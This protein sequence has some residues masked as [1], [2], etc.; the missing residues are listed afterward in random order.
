M[1]I[2][3]FLCCLIL[4]VRFAEPANA[5]VTVIQLDDRFRI[6]KDGA[7]VT[8]WHFKSWAV[9]YLYPVIGPNGENITRHYP[10][11]DGVPGESKDHPHH[12]SIRFSHRDLN[13]YSF[14]SPDSPKD[15]RARVD[16]VKVEKAEGGESSAELI[17]IN[18]WFG[19]ETL[20]LKERLRL[21]FTLLENNE[22]LIDYD[23]TLTAA[24]VDAT[25]VDQKDGGLGVRVA[26]TMRVAGKDKTPGKGTIQNSKGDKNEAAWGKRAEWADYYGPDASGKTVG[27]ATFDHPSNLRYP[28]HW[29]ART[30][31][32]ITANRFGTGHFEAKSGAKKGDGNYTIKKGE[33][34]TLRHRLYLHH[35]STEEA[36]VAERYQAY[37]QEK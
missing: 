13:G 18:H 9:P 19:D 27:I 37:V 5:E 15:K 24:D 20:I 31:G 17:L 33:T 12:R 35:G 21:K 14:W 16:L 34:I 23:T 25:F 32:L 6:E 3:A 7:V 8:E 10:M 2:S 28:T 4:L 30:Y 26:A 29:H 22:T 11:L 36:N 1:K